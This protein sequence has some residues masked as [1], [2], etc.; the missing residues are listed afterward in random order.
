MAQ[1][2]NPNSFDQ[3]NVIRGFID[4]SIHKSGV[5]SVM[6]SVNQATALK[7]GDA[8]KLDVAATGN[9]PQIIAAAVGDA[10]AFFITAAENKSSYVAGDICEIAGLFG[11]VMW[12]IAE[13]IIA[14]GAS[15]EQIANGN[16][17][18]LA[19][20]K[21]RGMA[22]LNATAGGPVPIMIMTPSVT[23]S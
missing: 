3:S 14:M 21:V 15:V 12:M 17:Q 19:A 1:L 8:V 23:Q 6:V 11:P 13:A 18:T 16:M 4:W 5:L 7:P 10:K 22:L 20:G 2:L 9:N